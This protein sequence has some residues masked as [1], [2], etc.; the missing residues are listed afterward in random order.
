MTGFAIGTLCALGGIFLAVLSDMVSQEIRDRL[1]HIPQ[2]I[3][4][5]AALRLD[6]GQR[7]TVY[8]EEWLPELTYILKREEARP[9]T[10]LIV[11]IWYAVDMIRGA[12]SVASQLNRTTP[13]AP[14]P[15]PASPE[16]T[17]LSSP[18]A[19][20]VHPSRRVDSGRRTA[21]ANRESRLAR[22]RRHPEFPLLPRRTPR[23]P[24]PI[25]QSGSRSELGDR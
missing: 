11:G 9:V 23:W 13:H 21:R 17:A 16:T 12:P 14:V 1:D 19:P 2:A 5:L 6:S 3:L 7:T 24:E 25:A 8:E 10:R 20:S 22:E 18:G 15:N 4:R